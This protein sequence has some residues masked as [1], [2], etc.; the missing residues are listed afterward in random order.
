MPK[1]EQDL[2]EET[3]E[4][5]DEDG[6]GTIDMEELSR[7]MHVLTGQYPSRRMVKA[8][9]QTVDDDDN[10]A[11]NLDEFKILWQMQIE[12]RKQWVVLN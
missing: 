5:I 4:E 1:A 3:F 10:G 11:I 6:S 9:F 7:A 12:F 8:M 2:C